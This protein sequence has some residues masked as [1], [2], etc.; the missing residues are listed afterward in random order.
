M[1]AKPRTRRA[2]RLRASHRRS[3]RWRRRCRSRRTQPPAWIERPPHPATQQARPPRPPR[4]SHRFSLAALAATCCVI[5]FM[6]LRLGYVPSAFPKYLSWPGSA[7]REP[8]ASA[9]GDSFGSWLPGA[10]PGR[11]ASGAKAAIS[12]VCVTVTVSKVA[13]SIK[14]GDFGGERGGIDI[15]HDAVL[16]PARAPPVAQHD[17]AVGAGGLARC[18]D[19]RGR[20]R[21]CWHV[22]HVDAGKAR[23]RVTRLSLSVAG[24]CSRGSGCRREGKN[25]DG[26][27]VSCSHSCTC[28]A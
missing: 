13:R 6:L 8:P 11:C 15:G 27:G 2:A 25:L 17:A 4:L 22:A 26:S 28:F 16:G 24:G 14:G 21:W 12:D 23:P 19:S 3:P 10:A 7:I 18:A 9:L 1:R 20:G 5:R